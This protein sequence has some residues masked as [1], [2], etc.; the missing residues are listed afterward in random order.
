MA[1][2][3]KQPGFYIS[4]LL[5]LD[6][7]KMDRFILKKKDNTNLVYNVLFCTPDQTSFVFCES[8]TRNMSIFKEET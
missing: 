1:C 7:I 5:D 3:T 2:C 4:P 8:I 6:K